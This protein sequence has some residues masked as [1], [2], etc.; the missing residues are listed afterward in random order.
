MVK[1]QSNGE[2]KEKVKLRYYSK[3]YQAGVSEVKRC[4]YFEVII[5]T[6]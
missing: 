5:T 4:K 2:R 6:R 3:K 1:I